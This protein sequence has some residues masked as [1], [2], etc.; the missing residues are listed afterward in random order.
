MHKRNGYG[1][2]I[3]EEYI[4]MSRE[5]ES[6]TWQAGRLKTRPMGKPVYDPMLPNGGH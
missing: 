5:N 3:V 4:S 6:A 2:D 1:C